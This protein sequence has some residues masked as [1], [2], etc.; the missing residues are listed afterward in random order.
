MLTA[1]ERPTSGSIKIN[2][3]DINEIHD[4]PELMKNIIGY[5]P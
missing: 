4:H 5:C 3:M 2:G 1:E